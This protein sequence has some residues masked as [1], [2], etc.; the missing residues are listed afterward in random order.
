MSL[1]R[2]LLVLLCLGA[3][4]APAVGSATTNDWF[5]WTNAAPMPERLGVC[6]AFVGLVDGRLVVAGGV[7]FPVPGPWSPALPMNSWVPGG[8]LPAPAFPGS[9]R[10]A[11]A[12]THPLSTQGSI[13]ATPAAEDRDYA[14]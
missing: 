9:G 1:R 6:G 5:A 12:D 2:L 13:G 11:A 14:F 4:F 3:T 10:Q 8:G 7:D